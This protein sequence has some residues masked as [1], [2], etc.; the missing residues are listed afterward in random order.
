MTKG[1]ESPKEKLSNQIMLGMDLHE[2][3]ISDFFDIEN[4]F[5]QTKDKANIFVR[6]DGLLRAAKRAFGGIKR[7]ESDALG[8]PLK[9]NNWA[10][11]VKVTYL[12]KT[13]HRAAAVADCR[14]DTANHG[15]GKYTTALAETRASGR[16]L[17]FALG[18]EIVTQEE[19]TDVEELID[20]AAREPALEQQK[21]LIKKKFMGERKK[22]FEDVSKVLKKK[23]VTL[24]QLTRGEA[25]EILE[26]FNTE[27]E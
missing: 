2:R 14:S 8:V 6:H 25:G 26:V 3:K 9:E 19:I 15:F 18:L 12:F 21:V 13:G 16:A 4:D 22:T 10:A 7:R 23:V 17:K 11:V 24:D 5:D 27:R 20:Q 1:K